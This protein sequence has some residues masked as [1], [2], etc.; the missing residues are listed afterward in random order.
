LAEYFHDD[1]GKIRAIAGEARDG[2][3]PIS[4]FDSPREDP[5]FMSRLPDDYESF[6]AKTLTFSHWWDPSSV[7]WDGARFLRFIGALAMG[8]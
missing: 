2:A 7:D 5:Q 3:D 8:N 1:W 6:E 4:L